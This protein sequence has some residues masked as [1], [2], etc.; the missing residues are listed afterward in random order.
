MRRMTLKIALL[1]ATVLISALPAL[2]A[3]GMGGGAMDQNRQGQKDEC[4]LVAKNCSD[5][6]DSI[7]QR[8]E[9]IN[10]EIGKGSAVYTRGELMKLN[11]ELE[12]AQRT[13]DNLLNNS[14]S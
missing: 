9:R 13:L 8:I 10:H 2:A 3:E 6:I 7:Q 4:L 1:I 14:G 12:D 5:Q 11:S